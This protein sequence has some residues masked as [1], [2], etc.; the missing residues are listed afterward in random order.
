MA[1]SQELVYQSG[2]LEHGGVGSLTIC[3]D[4]Q[5]PKA[6]QRVTRPTRAK[7]ALR[8]MYLTNRG[9]VAK[10]TRLFVRSRTPA[11]LGESAATGC[12]A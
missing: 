2:V 12:S 9:T 3:P 8:I 4:P 10:G 7:I 5:H 1:V 11:T 6:L